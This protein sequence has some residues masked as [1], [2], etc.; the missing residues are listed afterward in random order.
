MRRFQELQEGAVGSDDQ[1]D[2]LGG[3]DLHSQESMDWQGEGFEQALDSDA[4]QHGAP[5]VGS[6]ELPPPENIYVK[7]SKY[8]SSAVKLESCPEAKLPEFAVIGRSNVGKSSLINMLTNNKGLALTSK[9]PGV[10]LCCIRTWI[11]IKRR[12]RRFECFTLPQLQCRLALLSAAAKVGP[13]ALQLPCANA[14]STH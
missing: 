7:T 9:Q 5:A 8:V 14:F 1:D 10:I 2:F 11:V 3:D 4:R 13:C 6:D 12:W